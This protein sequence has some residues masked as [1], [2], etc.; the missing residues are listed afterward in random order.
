MLAGPF[1]EE[2]EARGG[3]RLDRL[4]LAQAFELDG[5]RG[6]RCGPPG[7]TMSP[8]RTRTRAARAPALAS[9]VFSITGGRAP[10]VCGV[11]RGVG[12][13]VA[14]RGVTVGRGASDGGERGE[15]QEHGQ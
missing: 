9:I 12:L 13:D 11:G 2:L 4:E 10:G 5:V 15:A 8:A 7:E 3:A 1:G 14:S 6:R